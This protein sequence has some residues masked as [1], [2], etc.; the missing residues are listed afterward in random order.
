VVAA[1]PRLLPI[2]TKIRIPPHRQMYTVGDTGSGIKGRELDI[3]MPSC[4]AARKFGRRHVRVEVVSRGSL[5]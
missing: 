2:G 4:R 3:Y 5:R 1:D